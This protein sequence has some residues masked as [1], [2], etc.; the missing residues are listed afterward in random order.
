M[1]PDE[2]AGGIQEYLQSGSAIAGNT[3]IGMKP[4][5]F[6]LP[7]RELLKLFGIFQGIQFGS[8]M[9]DDALMGW[10]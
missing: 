6:P 10:P 1:S 2:F 5:L 9:R 8:S 7:V 4:Q 3:H